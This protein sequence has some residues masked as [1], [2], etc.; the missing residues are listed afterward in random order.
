MYNTEQ[1]L[2]CILLRGMLLSGVKPS[3]E[4]DLYS[5]AKITVQKGHSPSLFCEQIAN[6]FYQCERIQI[7]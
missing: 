5:T 1:I 4:S 2:R 3:A 6:F 7:Y